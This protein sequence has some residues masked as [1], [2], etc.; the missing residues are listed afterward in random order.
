MKNEKITAFSFSL[1]LGIITWFT[2]AT[3][4]RKGLPLLDASIFEY[5][6]YAMSHGQR[7]YLELFDHKG[8]V[9]FLINYLGYSFGA[10]LGIKILYLKITL[11]TNLEKTD[12]SSFIIIQNLFSICQ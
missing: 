10:S 9:I 12:T 7:M 4:V 3:S 8:P 11:L 6:G 1:F 2:L 5:F